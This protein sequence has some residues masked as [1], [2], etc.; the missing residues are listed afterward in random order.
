VELERSWLCPAETRPVVDD[1]SRQIEQLLA[2]NKELRQ[3]LRG[4]T[5]RLKDLKASVPGAPAPRR[6]RR[7]AQGALPEL[8]I[9]V[10]QL[11]QDLS[12]V[13]LLRDFARR[14]Q[15]GEIG[16][17]E[18]L[19]GPATEAA[20]GD[21]LDWLLEEMREVMLDESDSPGRSERG[22]ARG[23]SRRGRQR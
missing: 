5:A 3:Q 9:F 13:K 12:N 2:A 19:A 14:F 23:R 21:D 4:L 17:T 15:R 22:S 11:E 6:G 18:F 20:E 10:E 1:V 16:L 7:S 8:D